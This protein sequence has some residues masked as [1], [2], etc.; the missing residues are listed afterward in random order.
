MY[1]CW[2]MLLAFTFS[3]E[4]INYSFISSCLLWSVVNFPEIL[5]NSAAH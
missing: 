5:V 4:L 1:K 2:E 3:L